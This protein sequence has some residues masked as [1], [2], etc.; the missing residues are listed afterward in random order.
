MS[1]SPNLH[2]HESKD[3]QE[4]G[5]R[6]RRVP[7]QAR[8]RER[9]QRILDAAAHLPTEEGYNSVKTNLIAKRAGVSIGSVYQFFPN[10]YV[11]IN[12]LG[13]RYQSKVAQV[14]MMYMGPDA[15]DDRHWDETLAEVIDILAEMWHDD[16]AFHSV[17]LAIRSTTE[18]QESDILF[19][20]NLIDSLLVNFWKKV[21]P[22]KDDTQ[23][24][25]I[26]RV[27]FEISN[28]MLDH[29]MRNGKKQDE[30]IVDELKFIL[31][32]YV[33]SHIS[34]ANNLTDESDY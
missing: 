19:R 33:T 30:L 20:E 23:P 11:I 13:E 24:K 31:H 9:V 17:W 2:L 28:L 3:S 18:L 5:I 12:A 26:A 14:L 21:I 7:V 1:Q 29:S 34:T 10:R 22:E 16:W 27:I 4:S 15:P 32:S 8:S 25:T 6:P